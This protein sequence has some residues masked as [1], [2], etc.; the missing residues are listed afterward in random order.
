MVTFKFCASEKY[1]WASY[2]G[3]TLAS[4]ARAAGSIPAAHSAKICLALALIV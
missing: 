2:S 1:L 3:N 4:Q